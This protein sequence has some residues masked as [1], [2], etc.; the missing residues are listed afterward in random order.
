MFQQAL[1]EKIKNV[2]LLEKE[3]LHL[4]NELKNKYP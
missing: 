3:D 1:N 4:F 2:N